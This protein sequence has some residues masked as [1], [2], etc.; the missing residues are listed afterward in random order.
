MYGITISSKKN[1]QTAN[2]LSHLCSFMFEQEFGEMRNFSAEDKKV[3]ENAKKV[4]SK[5]V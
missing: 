2:L 1:K 5:H 3:L 4:L